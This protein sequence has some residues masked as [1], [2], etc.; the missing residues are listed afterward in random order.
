MASIVPA[1]DRDEVLSRIDL[2][3]LAT[4]ICGPPSGS[5]RSA[6]WHCPNPDHPD[7]HP[8]MSVYQAQRSQR[9]K[10]HG[11]GE[12]GTAIDLWMLA[13]R[14]GVA[15]ALAALAERSGAHQPR[16]A[17]A[18]PSPTLARLL[19][20]KLSQAAPSEPPPEEQGAGREDADPATPRF[21]VGVEHYVASAEQLLWGQQGSGAL[22]WLHQRGLRDDVLHAN[23]VGYD[24][25]RRELRRTGGLPHRGIGVVL[26]ILG[27][28]DH[29]IW[30]QTRY[31]DPGSAGRKYDS[32]VADIAP[33]PKV[34]VIRPPARQVP[35]SP[36]TVVITEGIPDGLTVAHTGTQAAA[37]VG[38]GNS[39]PDVAH[40]LHRLWPQAAFV[41]AFDNDAAGQLTGPRL[42]AHLAELGHDVAVATP[43]QAHN[44]L[45]DWWRA[46]SD[47]FTQHLAAATRPALYP[48]AAYAALPTPSL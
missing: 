28:G 29:A 44:D 38:T 30:V 6:K 43:P 48:P 8:S 1:I 15:D 7:S 19:T 26:P 9:W 12:G 3:V 2:A 18:P 40:R 23:R 5:G 24:P 35:E 47:G 27:P 14:V 34:A 31:L 20:T 42:A 33:N 4:E 17:A 37:V 46:D 36:S 32:V 39:G 13:H 22:L 16:P 21:D 25:G 10:C 11:C 45:N 41:V